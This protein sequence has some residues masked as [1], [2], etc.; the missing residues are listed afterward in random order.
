MENETRMVIARL[1]PN[2]KNINFRTKYLI[3]RIPFAPKLPQAGVR[4]KSH[5]SNL[6]MDLKTMCRKLGP[7]NL[8]I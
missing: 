7:L 8:Q 5:A 2:F 1:N 4:L 3:F 6:D